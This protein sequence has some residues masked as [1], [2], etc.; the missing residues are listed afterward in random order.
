MK[1]F[2]SLLAVN[3][4]AIFSLRFAFASAPLLR[5]YFSAGLGLINNAGD[6]IYLWASSG[7]EHDAD[8]GILPLLPFA[9]LADE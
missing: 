7:N 4:P 6:I 8:S 9:E 2:F 5:S 1:L 3:I